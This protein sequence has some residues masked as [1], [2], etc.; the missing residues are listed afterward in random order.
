MRIARNLI[1]Y[2][3]GLPIL[4]VFTLICGLIYYIAFIM[5]EEFIKIDVVNQVTDMWK[6][7]K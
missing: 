3:L 5:G 4:V 1:K 6:A 2:V 7:L